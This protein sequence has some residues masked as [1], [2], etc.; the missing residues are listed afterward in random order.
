ML[1][2]AG[3][4]EEFAPSYRTGMGYSILSFDWNEIAFIGSP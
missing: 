1:S 3:G 2:Y 4:P